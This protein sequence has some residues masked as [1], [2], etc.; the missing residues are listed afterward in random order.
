MQNQKDSWLLPIAIIVAGLILA[1][2]LY[3]Y[4]IHHVVSIPA[5]EVSHIRAV[6]NTDHIM[7]NPGAPIKI[8]EYA[9][10][11]SSYAKTFQVTMEQLMANYAA[12]GKV[13]WVYRHFPLVDQHAY[14]EQHAEAAEC[15]AKLGGPT[16]FLQFIDAL[17]AQ[18]PGSQL[19]DPRNYDGVVSALGVV[20]QSFHD[21]IKS[22]EFQQRVARDFDNGLLIGSGGS[23]FTVIEVQNQ[24]PVIINGAVPYDSLK[25]IIDTSIA[26][27]K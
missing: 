26:A 6:D 8:I 24:K 27:I 3:R 2:T 17:N 23:P 5:A 21:C 7:G 4:R 16:L 10:I 14:S 20:S 11:D 18:A 25:K 12:G 15:I 1:V 19:F 13:A 22:G 9:D